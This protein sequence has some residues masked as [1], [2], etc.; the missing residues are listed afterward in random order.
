MSAEHTTQGA[1]QGGFRSATARRPSMVSS[2]APPLV[3]DLPVSTSLQ[4]PLR[5]T[6][7]L[8]HSCVAESPPPSPY[9]EGVSREDK[10]ASVYQSALSA[11]RL[12]PRECGANRLEGE[13]GFCGAGRL[14]KVA[15]VSVHHGEEPP[16]SGTRGSGTI[17]F[18]HCNM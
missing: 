6:P 11:C 7:L 14:A 17:F 16:I 3:P 8:R 5:G 10:G 2:P 18:S 4:T 12:C 15:A 13:R 1:S 9:L